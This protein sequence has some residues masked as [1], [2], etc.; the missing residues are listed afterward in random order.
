MSN[1]TFFS[2]HLT[3]FEIWLDFGDKGYEA[4]M[5]LPILLQVLQVEVGVDVEVEVEILVE[6]CY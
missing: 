6:V 4:P 5:H 1:S 3:A 2:E